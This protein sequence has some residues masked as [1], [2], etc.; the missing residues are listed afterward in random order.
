MVVDEKYIEKVQNEEEKQDFSSTLEMFGIEASNEST[1]NGV[2]ITGYMETKLRDMYDGDECIGRPVLT[3]IYTVEFKDKNT[4]ET[5]INHKIDLLLFDDSYEDEKEVYVF[6]INLNSDNI[7][8]EKNVVKNVNSASGLYAL[9]MG[10]ME[11]ETKGI[12]KAFN[13]LD[14]VPFV[15]LK[16]IIEGYKSVMV[17]VVEKQ[18]N[19][20]YYNSFRIIE[21]EKKE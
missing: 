21:G 13:K 2:D 5:I 11:L 17:Q 10:F 18:F 9:A 6:P 8:F 12:S 7:D 4:G 3:D 1:G 16:K 19:N 15:Q 20:N 14:V